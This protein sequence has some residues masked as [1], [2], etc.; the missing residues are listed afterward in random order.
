MTDLT[1]VNI[2]NI[3]WYKY[4]LPNEQYAAFDAD[5]ELIFSET[6]IVDCK[7]IMWFSTF[8][9][10]IHIRRT[11][12]FPFGKFTGE[13]GW[14]V[15]WSDVVYSRDH[16][17]YKDEIY[18][19]DEPKQN[20]IIV[21]DDDSF[22]QK[23]EK[24]GK[25]LTSITNAMNLLSDEEAQRISATTA[26]SPDW[27]KAPDW[28]NWWAVDSEDGEAWFFEEEPFLKPMLTD[29]DEYRPTHIY[30]DING[31]GLDNDT[32]KYLYYDKTNFHKSLTKRPE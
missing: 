12:E 3:D 22:E 21:T 11:D 28:A 25:M 4:A 15:N 18:R 1:N 10:G 16:L 24:L 9:E 8:G 27:N 32:N 13:D 26:T 20:N 31:G 17:R 29:N 23:M 6:P 5:G 14:F 2:V 19:I 7:K 30:W